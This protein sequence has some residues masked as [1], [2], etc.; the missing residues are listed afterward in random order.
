M[1][2]ISTCAYACHTVCR[3]MWPQRIEHVDVCIV[4]L[5][6][7]I[8]P[9]NTDYRVDHLKSIVEML[10]KRNIEQEKM[11]KEMDEKQERLI[12]EMDERQ[13]K[14]MKE[15]IDT[16]ENIPKKQDVPT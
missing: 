5:C 2:K 10:I 3:W 16:L 8:F 13:D 7:S 1:V 4:H 11:I 14:M 6:F 15:V 9:Q 12:K